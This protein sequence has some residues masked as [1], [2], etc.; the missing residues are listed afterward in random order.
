[1]NKIKFL[2]ISLMQFWH[3][4]NTWAIAFDHWYILM[5]PHLFYKNWKYDGIDET[6]DRY[7]FWEALNNFNGLLDN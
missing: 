6:Q 5:F 2:D 4:K 3:K 1:M 7:W